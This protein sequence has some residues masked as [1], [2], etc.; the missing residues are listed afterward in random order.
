[1]SKELDRCL[2]DF[3]ESGIVGQD[4]Q[5]LIETNKKVSVTVTSPNEPLHVEIMDSGYGVNY[6]DQGFFF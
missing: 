1:M 2:V 4:I 5:F 3:P 6:S